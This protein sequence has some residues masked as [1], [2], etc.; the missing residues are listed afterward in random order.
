MEE[1]T[2]DAHFTRYL[3]ISEKI[4]PA[5]SDSRDIWTNFF[6]FPSILELKNP[7]KR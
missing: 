2:V 1:G 4:K 6:Y 3:A 7:F 5:S